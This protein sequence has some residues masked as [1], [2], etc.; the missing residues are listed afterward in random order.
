M[1]EMP[2]A[3]RRGPGVDAPR[4]PISGTLL[5][6]DFGTKRIGIAVGETQAGKGAIRWDHP[7]A[8]GGVGSTGSPVANALARE[9]DLVIGVGTR[10]SDFTTASRTAFQHPEVRFVSWLVDLSRSGNR[11]GIRCFSGVR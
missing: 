1:R 9:A 4:D 7:Q 11:P 10:Y 6:F 5:A 2:A 8:V 3:G